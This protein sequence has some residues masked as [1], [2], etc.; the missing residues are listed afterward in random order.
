VTPNDPAKLGT[1][2]NE[3]TGDF[4]FIRETCE[5]YGRVRWRDEV[6]AIARPHPYEDWTT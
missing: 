2:V 1:W 3:Y 4:D 5:A 6:I